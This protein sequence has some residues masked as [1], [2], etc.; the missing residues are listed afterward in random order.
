MSGIRNSAAVFNSG[1]GNLSY[2]GTVTV[3]HVVLS[4][5]G[6][7]AEQWGYGDT[8]RSITGV[9]FG[10]RSPTTT[11]A[12]PIVGLYWEFSSPSGITQT[13]LV[14][15]GD[16]SARGATMIVN[17]LAQNLGTGVYSSGP[18]TTTYQ[19]GNG[20]ANPFGAVASTATVTIS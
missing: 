10:S 18:N 16:S 17:G 2:S 5:K 3:G 20:Q 7:A 9:P 1:G 14:V 12:F 4:G 8:T 19:S 15:T 13:R 6:F 11:S